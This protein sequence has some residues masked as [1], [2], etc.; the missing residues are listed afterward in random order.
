M[1]DPQ[2]AELTPEALAVLSRAR[3]TFAITM[4]L[5][6]L[7]FM[8]IGVVLVYRASRA[9]SETK[10]GSEYAIASIKVPAGAEIISA[11]AAEGRI[12]LTYRIGTV[13]SIRIIDGKTGDIVREMPIVSE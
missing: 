11:V 7:G 12:T 8:V 13:A 4:G 10:P 5:L 6:L 1:S 9:S 3:R 2:P